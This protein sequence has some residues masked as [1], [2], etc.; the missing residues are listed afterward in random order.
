MSET[1]AN[2]STHQ[3]KAPLKA[4][5]ICLVVTWVLF[6]IPFPGTG[7]IGWAVNLAAIILAIVSIVRGST[8]PAIIQLVIGI[9]LSPI[10]YFIGL[11]IFAALVVSAG[12]R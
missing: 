12:H 5:W 2:P 6:L 3:A 10:V 8:V 9:V 1:H 4:G 7:L 11:S